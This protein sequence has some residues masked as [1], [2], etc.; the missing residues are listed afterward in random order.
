MPGHNPYARTYKNKHDD[1]YGRRIRGDLKQRYYLQGPAGSTREQV[2][3]FHQQA[4]VRGPLRVHRRSKKNP[5]HTDHPYFGNPN[6]GRRRTR[7]H[8][9]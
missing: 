9:R 2:H 1:A 3:T 5:H 4:T 8:R 7:R 6:G